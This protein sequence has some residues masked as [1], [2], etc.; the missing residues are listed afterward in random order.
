M[1]YLDNIFVASSLLQL[2][3]SQLLI[4]SIMIRI[5]L[6]SPWSNIDVIFFWVQI[7]TGHI[8]VSMH[9]LFQEFCNLLL[10]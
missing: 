9:L 7:T 2:C 1:K 3:P 8:V 5:I 10:L 4:Y 6:L